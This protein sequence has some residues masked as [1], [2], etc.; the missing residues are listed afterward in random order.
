MTDSA[1]TVCVFCGSRAGALA[2]YADDARAIGQGLAQRGWGLV[3]GGGRIGLMGAVA[4]ASRLGGAWVTGV[5]PESLMQRE[6][7]HRG[8]DELH[9]V[10]TMHA[11][12]QMMAE[13]ADAFIAL[14]GGLGTFEELFEVWT[15]RQL[16]YHSRPIALLNTAGY[17]D[18]LLQFLQ[19]SVEQG[20]VF[21]KQADMLIVDSDPEALLDRVSAAFQADGP[22]PDLART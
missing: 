21:D 13:R 12:K 17:Y 18:G 4:D 1:R 6:V 8:L 7:G 22:A 2:A 3:Y 14:P 5:I 16:G 19:T 9:V 15:W 11:R 20:F 10:P